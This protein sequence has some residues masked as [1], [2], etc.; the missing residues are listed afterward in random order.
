MANTKHED[1]I[2]KM[3]FDYFRD[4]ILKQLG[5]NYE[6]VDSGPTELVDVAVRSMYMDFTFLTTEDIYIHIEFQTTDGGVNDL[7]R[8]RVYEAGYSYKTGKQVITYVIYSGGIREVRDQLQCGINTYRIL[9]IYLN[10]QSA[11]SVFER[12]KEKSESGEDFTEE[13]YAA[14]SL[15]PLMAGHLSRK[16]TIKEAIL[17]AKQSKQLT[18]EKTMAMLYALA[19]KFLEGKDLKEIKEVVAMTRIGQMLLDE[20]MEKGIAR[21]IE[22]GMAKGMEKG[23]EQG[24]SL[25]RA[26]MTE[27]NR[28]LLDANRIEDLRRASEDEEFCRKLMEELDIK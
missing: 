15:T 7:R 10:D 17:L 5:I 1:A 27:L 28:K 9:P 24:Y 4:T 14:L 18:A 6:F 19:D 11:D 21:G 8:F 25:A 26:Q 23:I 2:M 13:D 20:G 12:I 16:D 3:G 22:Q